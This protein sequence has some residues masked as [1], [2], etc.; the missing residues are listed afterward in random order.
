MTQAEPTGGGYLSW[1]EHSRQP[2][3]AGFGAIPRGSS[4]AAAAC[5]IFS[6]QVRPVLG[7]PEPA[8]T[9]CCQLLNLQLFFGLGFA[10]T[11]CKSFRKHF[12]W[13]TTFPSIILVPVNAWPAIPIITM[14]VRVALALALPLFP[15]VV[16]PTANLLLFG[17]SFANFVFYFH[18]R[19]AIYSVRM[20]SFLTPLSHLLSF[21]PTYFGCCFCFFVVV[22]L[23][24]GW[25]C[26]SCSQAKVMV[27]PW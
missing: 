7:S 18:P 8:G 25:G 27:K 24:L 26:T 1:P 9:H 20:A 3:V 2:A 15:F 11:S 4:F 21:C 14:G 10:C 6:T 5:A 13:L 23:F 17:T 12:C 22:L 19:F 16:A